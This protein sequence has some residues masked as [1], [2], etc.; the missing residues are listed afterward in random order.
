[1]D[2]GV[3]AVSWTVIIPVKD[4]SRA[5]SRMADGRPA[6]SDLARAFLADV[7]DAVHP[8][9]LVDR[10]IVATSDPEAMAIATAHGALSVDDTGHP[11]INAGA[12]W[13]ARSA[14]AGTGV[15]V[16]V[17]DL[18]RLTT[19][20]VSRVLELAS[21]HPVSFVADLQGTGT[22]MWLALSPTLMPPHFGA[23]SRQA[24]LA[25]GAVD[26]VE[27]Y[28]DQVLLPARA[29]A[30]TPEHLEG[31]GAGRLGPHTRQALDGNPASTPHEMPDTA[32]DT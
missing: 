5:K 2:V 26:L 21:A 25:T 1:L 27:R 20:A 17:S 10:I 29:D 31:A 9:P 23:E 11:G 7:L 18:P 15:A 28:P 6:P 14:T 16:M 32:P 8:C 22:T 4:L 13:A 3:A 24:H 30:D 12:T 19:A